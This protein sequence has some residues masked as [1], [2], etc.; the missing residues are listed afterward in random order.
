MSGLLWAPLAARLR[1]RTLECAARRRA[2]LIDALGGVADLHADSRNRHVELLGD[3]LSERRANAGP[4]IDFAREHAHGA[5][6]GNGEPR[7]QLIRGKA[8][9]V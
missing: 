8:A 1:P 2:A 5:I 4:E 7:V 9:D 3:D 6:G